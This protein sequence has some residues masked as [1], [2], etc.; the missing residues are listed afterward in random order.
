M[1]E[2]DRLVDQGVVAVRRALA[3]AGFHVVRIPTVEFL[4]KTYMAYTNGVFGTW[5]ERKICARFQIR[6][7]P[8]RAGP[9]GLLQ[10]LADGMKF[11]MKEEFI[12]GET[13][14]R[15]LVRLRTQ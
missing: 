3:D 5:G 6:Y 7:G 15:A 14:D 2:L 8:N 10:P 9:F 4:D 13:L 11:F 12:P 1:S